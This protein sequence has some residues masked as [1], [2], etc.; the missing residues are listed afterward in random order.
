M[1]GRLLRVVFGFAAAC[2][3]V[4]ATLVLFVLTPRDLINM[5]PDVA[6]DRLAKGFD[7][8]VAVAAQSALFSAPFALVAA[9]VGEALR[10]RRWTFYAVCGLLIAALGLF[11]QHST[12][13]VGQATI[14]NSYAGL[15]FLSA[16]LAGGL[17]YWLVSG[18]CAGG[19]PARAAKPIA[20]KAATTGAKPVR[21][22]PSEA[23]PKHE[24]PLQRETVDALPAIT[25]PVA[26]VPKK[27]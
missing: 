10:S 25:A 11:A 21:V 17:T 20:S 3:A 12:E 16:G 23:A 4:G 22:P 24:A 9:A 27:F 8:A 7:L 15:A 19:R 5:P 14:L 6:S 2:V 1:L 13:Q 18:R 26:A